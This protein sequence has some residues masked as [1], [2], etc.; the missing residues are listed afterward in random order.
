MIYV[1][2]ARIPTEKAHGIQIMKMADAF[3]KNGAALELVI[4]KR[5]NWIKKNP[6]EYYGIEKGF[7]IT[8]LPCLDLIPLDKY[9]GLI[10]LWLETISFNLF[11]WPYIFFKRADIIYTRDKFLLPLV[12]FKKNLTLE[13]HSLPRNYFLYSL[14]LKKIKAIVVTS[15]NLK[16]FFVQ[17]GISSAGIMAVPNAV[18][19]EKF[20]INKELDLDLPKN[21][22]IIL[23]TGHLYEWKGV[24]T[25]LEA[26]RNFQFSMPNLQFIFVG[27]TAKDIQEFKTKCLGIQNIIVVGHR[28]HDEIP[29]WLK[30]ADVLVL[31]DSAKNDPL[32]YGASPLKMFEYMASKKPIVASNLPSITEILNKDNA[33]L[34]APDNP[35]SLAEG[36]KEALQNSQLSDKI[37]E[38]AF[39]DVQNYTWAKR[40]Q[41]I[42]NFI[43]D[44]KNFR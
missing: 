19:L 25:L 26:A 20:K 43:Y 41:K 38:R 35:E 34:V 29:S 1:T 39:Q 10:G 27:G 24:D 33:I 42:L 36:I 15:Q 14:F 30:A 7:K 21:K 11:A 12:L 28:P 22:K 31:P 5:F 2:N 16:D 17:R 32:K 6:F 37:S 13:F 3:V 4:P 18:D 23:Y 40:A 9:I 44:R 8:R